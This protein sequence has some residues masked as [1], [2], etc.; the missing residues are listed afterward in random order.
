MGQAKKFSL[1]LLRDRSPLR[2][3]QKTAP[4]R[5]SVIG[6]PD[7]SLAR[8]DSAFVAQFHTRRKFEHL[9]ETR[10]AGPESLSKATKRALT[11]RP[12]KKAP[13]LILAGVLDHGPSQNDFTAFLV[14]WTCTIE[15]NV[16][17]KA[18][19]SDRDTES[20]I[21]KTIRFLDGCSRSFSFQLEN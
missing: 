12:G 17:S 3:G 14:S 16:C 18:V 9:H 4:R 2:M 21:D 11:P 13:P 10:I 1:P 19:N 5:P 8:R 7:L 20:A 6:T 15:P